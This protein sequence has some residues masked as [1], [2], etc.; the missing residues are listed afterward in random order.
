MCPSFEA[1]T[2]VKLELVLEGT[3]KHPLANEMCLQLQAFPSTVKNFMT[4]SGLFHEGGPSKKR[5]R[6]N[7][8]GGGSTN[9]KLLW[10]LNMLKP[11][12]FPELR[13]PQPYEA[14][15]FR[16]ALGHFQ[17]VSGLVPFNLTLEML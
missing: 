10:G 15:K 11:L 9:L 8:L 7:V 17:G 4:S 1:T 2:P 5:N 16:I 6:T 3:H 14:Y 13:D 12:Y